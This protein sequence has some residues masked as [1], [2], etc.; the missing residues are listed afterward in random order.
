MI[1]PLD[2]TSKKVL[3]AGA[4]SDIGKATAEQIARLGASILMVDKNGKE[5]EYEAGKLN[6]RV[7]FNAFDMYNL[8]IIESEIKQ[9]TSE[10][11]IFDG[12][13]YCGG[14]GGVRPLSLTTLSFAREMMDK[15]FN[16]FL[17]ISRCVIRKSSFASGGSIV[18]V[19][20]VSSIKGLKSKILYSASK[21]AL[22]AA[23][24]SMAAELSDR[25]IR[26][27]SIQKG[28]VTSDMNK[29][30][31]K[32]NMELAKNDDYKRQLLGAIEPIEIANTIAFLLSDSAKSITGTAIVV[33]GGYTL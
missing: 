30:F 28:W 24:R 9:I 6:E 10:H 15:N 4:L 22:D 7:S 3:I 27:N 13:V 18:A 25:R 20:S 31:I 21:A 11:G 5:L 16:T 17:E 26:V 2:L 19:S 1:N 29:D 33:D 23:V 32:N 14:I 8:E 12:F